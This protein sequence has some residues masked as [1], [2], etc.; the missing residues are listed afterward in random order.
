MRRDRAARLAVVGVAGIALMGLLGVLYAAGAAPKAFNLDDEYTVP[1]FYSS[2]LLAVAALM[3]FRLG[4]RREGFERLILL[5]GATFLAFL[6]L[7]EV[8]SL[9][10]RIDYRTG[11]DWQVLY[12]P[13]ALGFAWGV[14]RVT[15]ELGR[16]TAEARMIFAGMG[17]W[18]VAQM[19]EAAAFSEVTPSLVDLEHMSHQEVLDIGGSLV[20]QAIAIPEELLEMAGVLLFAVAFARALGRRAA[21]TK[22]ARRDGRRRT[23]DAQPTAD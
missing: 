17:A 23:S 1:A 6:A 9:H 7:D 13:A 18:V 20:Y 21:M 16:R 15:G 14:W 3:V 11:I 19:L 10:E 12:M 5:L 22:M 2:L 4:R 8:F